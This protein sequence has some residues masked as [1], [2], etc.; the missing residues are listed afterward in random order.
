MGV[1]VIFLQMVSLR[2]LHLGNIIRSV[3][4]LIRII[5]DERIEILHTN[6]SRTTLY[7][8][9]VSRMLGVPLVWHVR[10]AMKEP[11]YD[12]ILYHLATKIIAI[13]EAVAER[14]P[15]RGSERKVVIVYNGLDTQSFYSVDADHFRRKLG[16][17][18]KIIIGQVGQIHP[19]KGPVYLIRAIEAIRDD[20]PGV[21][22]LIVG[23][24]TDHQ[25]ELEGLVNQLQLDAHVTFLGWQE[26]VREIMSALDILVVPSQTEG[27]GRVLIEGMA[28]ERA[29]VAF[30]VDAIP[31]VIESGKSGV[32]VEKGNLQEFVAALN[33]LLTDTTLRERIAK[34]GRERVQ[35]L[36]DIRESVKRTEEIYD[37]C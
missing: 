32:L 28:C 9:L 36:F 24:P 31:E 10:I 13:S 2:T 3:R 30:S 8:G 21:H 25:K 15:C 27:F 19:L 6:A 23:A 34:Q 26:D 14:F 35:N 4:N 33:S 7:A 16:L 37:L 12:R 11:F 29:V 17:E 5:R 20:F 1:P 18:N 22:G